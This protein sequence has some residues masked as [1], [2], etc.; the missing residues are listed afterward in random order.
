MMSEEFYCDRK[1]K[2]TLYKIGMFSK[3]NHVTIKALRFYD[4]MGV[5][6][7]EQ[8][9][10][11]TGYRYYTSDQLPALHKII[12]L[13]NMGLTLEEIKHV[14]NGVSERELL[15][16]KKL[17]LMKEIAEQ[18]MKLTQVESYLAGGAIGSDYHIIVKELPEVVVVSMRVTMPNYNAIFHVVPAMGEEMERLNCTCAV[19]DY[20]FNIYHDDD[21][22]EEDI[23]VEICQAVTT[24]KK[25]S[26]ILKFKTIPKIDTAACVLHK[27]SYDGLPQVYNTVLNWVN[28]NGFEV[29]DHA[30][31]S[32]IDGVWNKDSEKDWLTEI[33]FPIKKVR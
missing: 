17:E 5:L 6:K 25:D 20:C 15:R 14:Q 18:T 27:G 21:Y 3:M 30:R 26:N 28:K 4:D 23:D 31:E 7:P 13:K 29:I 16:N 9:D 24:I 10:P 1:E 12:C 2:V 8:I 22:K 11:Y 32:Y 19:P 33:Q